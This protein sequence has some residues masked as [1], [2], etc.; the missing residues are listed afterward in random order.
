MVLHAQSEV[1]EFYERLG[2]TVTSEEFLE[3]GITHVEMRKALE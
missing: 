2:Y 1:Q 3:A